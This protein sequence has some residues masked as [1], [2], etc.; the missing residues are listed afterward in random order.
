MLKMYLIEG[1]SD[2]QSEADQDSEDR[3]GQCVVKPVT[4]EEVNNVSHV[5]LVSHKW[6]KC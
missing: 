3:L 1:I 5:I 4:V 6:R 2:Q